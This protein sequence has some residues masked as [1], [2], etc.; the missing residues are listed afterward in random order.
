[1]TQYRPIAVLSTFYKIY[2]TILISICPD[3]MPKL[4]REH[5]GFR[6]GY[7]ALE[8]ISTIRLIIEKQNEYKRGLL[9]TQADVYKAFDTVEHTT[10]VKALTH[11]E[12]DPN[13][14]KAFLREIRECGMKFRLPDGSLTKTIK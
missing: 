14:I 1:M 7:Q 9:C 10:I 4:G 11:Y 13:T 12:I 8:S 2:E 6:K 5:M 3:V